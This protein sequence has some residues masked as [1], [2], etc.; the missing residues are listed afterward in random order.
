MK[1]SIRHSF[2]SCQYQK[3]QR[4]SLGSQALDQDSSIIHKQRFLPSCPTLCYLPMSY[5]QHSSGPKVGSRRL[6][7]QE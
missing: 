7:V 1:A 2:Y 5:T 6:S 3:D 4:T